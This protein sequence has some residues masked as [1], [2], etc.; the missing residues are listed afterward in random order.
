MSLFIGGPYDG[1]NIESHT[2]SLQVIHRGNPELPAETSIYL[3]CKLFGERWPFYVYALE[4]M[5]GDDILRAL[6]QGY[7][8]VK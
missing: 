5:N 3:R 1:R 2:N 8:N 7:K 6:I 4:S